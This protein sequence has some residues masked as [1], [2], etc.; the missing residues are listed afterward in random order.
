MSEGTTV[1]VPTADAA[2]ILEAARD[3]YDG[4]ICPPNY[5]EMC[6]AM[7]RLGDQLDQPQG[8]AR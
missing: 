3:A 8:G 5:E 7:D 4:A 2:L 1:S 6:A